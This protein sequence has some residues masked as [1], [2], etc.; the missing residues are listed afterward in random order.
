MKGYRVIFI[1]LHDSKDSFER[2]MALLG[3]SS[4]MV[5]TIIMKAP[6]ILKEKM[7]L[8]YAR[9]YAEA[10]YLAGGVVRIQENGTINDSRKTNHPVHIP[11]L[12][13]FIMCPE[14]GHKQ[15]RSDNCQRCDFSFI[16]E[17]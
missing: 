2:G 14:C 17:A 13:R 5:D 8:E 11:T 16:K 1:G 12:D 4:D 6:V 15:L 9:R 7:T 3:V 10:I